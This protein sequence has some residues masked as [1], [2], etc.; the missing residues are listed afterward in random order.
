MD[1]GA[2]IILTFI[3]VLV[4]GFFVAAEY[5]FVR[6]RGTQLDELANTGS[7]RAKLASRIS[8]DIQPYISTFQL[9]VTLAS[10]GVGLLG[11]PA[12]GRLVRPVLGWLRD[13]SAGAFH[14]ARFLIASALF[15]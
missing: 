10:L 2:A 11:E 9:G 13:M 7:A 1:A 4:N 14:G 15:S 3:L 6:V 12:V 8:G 5:S